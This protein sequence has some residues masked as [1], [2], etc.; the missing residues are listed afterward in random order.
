M[1]TLLALGT[2]LLPYFAAA[3]VGVALS[4]WVTNAIDDADLA[5]EKTAHA[6]D[7]LDL[8]TQLGEM[9]A[10]AA[11]AQRKAD[12]DR[13]TAE[14]KIEQADA[15]LT[16]EKQTH[17]ADNRNYTAALAAGTQRLRVA[18]RSCSASR[19]NLPAAPG[20]ASVDD[21]ATTYADLDPAVASRV[22]TVAGDDEQQI[23]KLRGLQAWACAIRPDLP[24][25]R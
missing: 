2:R 10:A 13:R 8:T 11:E 22:F 16:K 4:A 21:G 24:A 17:E 19:D 5:R 25:C 6:Q 23:D 20:A 3:T 18:V 7:V 12:T 9:R 1:T 15:T 14:L